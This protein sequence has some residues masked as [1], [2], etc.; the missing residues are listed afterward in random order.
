MEDWG[1]EVAKAQLLSLALEFNFDEQSTSKCLDP[2]V[3]LYGDEGREFIN[4]E[5]CSDDF[6]AELAITMQ[7]TEDWDDL[8]AAE[9]ETCGVL[10]DMFGQGIPNDGE[11]NV[12]HN[13]NIIEDSPQLEKNQTFLK[14]DSSTDS[15]DE[16]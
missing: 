13:V 1:L 10:T 15:E 8:Q 14:V 12:V 4:V 6:P 7:D 2:L 9:S 3:S 11:C 16:D 5:H